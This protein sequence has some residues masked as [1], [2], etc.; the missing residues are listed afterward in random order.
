MERQRITVVYDDRCLFCQA[1]VRWLRQLDRHQRLA[2]VPIEPDLLA[3][4]H[5]AL[6]AEACQREIHV[7][8]PDGRVLA[9]WDGVVHLARLFP[10][11]WFLGVLGGIVPFRWLGCHLYRFVACH[12]GG[13]VNE[14][15]CSR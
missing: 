15:G 13:L 11:A 2:Y 12:R 6:T 7:V 8:T 5:P 10:L 3:Q 9:G 14:K 4:V 1:L